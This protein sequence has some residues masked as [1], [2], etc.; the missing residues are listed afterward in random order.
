LKFSFSMSGQDNLNLQKKVVAVGVLTG[1]STSGEA[2][3]AELL[4]LPDNAAKDGTEIRVRAGYR[5]SA[6]ADSAA[7]LHG[8]S[9]GAPLA[10]FSGIDAAQPASL[11]ETLA[12][13]AVAVLVTPHDPSAGM[14]RDAEMTLAMVHAARDAGVRHVVVVGSWTAPHAETTVR[15]IGARFAPVEAALRAGIPA[16]DGTVLGFTVLRGGFFTG[17][18]AAMM[19]PS[20]RG[21]GT[22][23]RF[24]RFVIPPVDPRD[25]GRCAARVAAAAAASAEGAAQHAGRF[26]EM[27]GP[28]V[29]DTA[30]IVAAISAGL[31]RPLDF[32]AINVESACANVP[33]FLAELFRA[34][35]ADDNLIPYPGDVERILGAKG[36]SVSAWVAEH[37]DRFE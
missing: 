17:N 30:G 29:L 37:A 35:A 12:G 13:C 26:Y 24:P 5:T 23:V 4:R 32:S 25:I 22:V 8:R 34:M 1:S 28:E 31:G 27:A 6:K 7:A 36:T 14:D 9:G 11:A 20:I 19:G 15:T 3:I 21:A 2:C 18:L 10:V 33:P 16:A